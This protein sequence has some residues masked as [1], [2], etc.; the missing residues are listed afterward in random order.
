MEKSFV[1]GV[2]NVIRQVVLPGEG[3]EFIL[4][5]T[6]VDVKGVQPDLPVLIEVTPRLGLIL[7]DLNEVAI[8]VVGRSEIGNGSFCT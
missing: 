7:P 1:G 6:A 3:D 5:P 4:L 8:P 2:V